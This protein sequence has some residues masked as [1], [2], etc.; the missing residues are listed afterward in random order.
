MVSH[1]PRIPNGYVYFQSTSAFETSSLPIEALVI[2]TTPHISEDHSPTY[3]DI[4]IIFNSDD[5]PI[6]EENMEI[7]QNIQKSGIH[8]VVS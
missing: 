1:N 5:F 6:E 8:L 4:Y 2:D 3:K 7:Y